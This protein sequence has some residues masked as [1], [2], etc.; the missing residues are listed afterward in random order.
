MD[1]ALYRLIN[2]FAH[3]T[4]F[5][6]P[7]IVAYAKYGLA[8]FAGLLLAGWWQA[9]RAGDRRA[10]AASLWGGA[11]A[12]AALGVAQLIGQLVDRAR[13]YTLMP[14][15]HVLIDRTT[16]FSFPSDHATAVGAVAAGLWLAN[17]RLGR[18]T[19]GLAILM[20]FARVYVGA[21]Y[22]GDVLGGLV[23]GAAFVLVLWPLASRLLGPV[24]AAIDRSPLDFLLGSAHDTV[25]AEGKAGLG[26]EAEAMR[27]VGEA[28]LADEMAIRGVEGG[29]V[30]A[31]EPQDLPVA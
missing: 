22:P 26:L 6:H 27:P 12:L 15:A 18:L 20:A 21:H 16:D 25:V 11:G 24:L 3:S 17:R 1:A 2:R 10:L 31:G 30:A 9:R 19:A 5:A 4:G 13:P 14:A 28:D 8:L 7:V 23:V 29:V